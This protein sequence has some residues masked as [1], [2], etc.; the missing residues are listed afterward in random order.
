MNAKLRENIEFGRAMSAQAHHNSLREIDTL[1]KEQH[2]CLSVI[3]SLRHT[4]HCLDASGLINLDGKGE[5]EEAK[6]VQESINGHIS[7]HFG[8]SKTINFIELDDFT[9]EWYDCFGD[10]DRAEYDDDVDNWICECERRASEKKES[11]NDAVENFL[12]E[13][14]EEHKTSYTPNGAFRVV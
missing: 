3:C 9:F 1:T 13:I 14:D 10:D 2:D 8:N 11:W 4:L 5:L 12:S 6:R 7:E